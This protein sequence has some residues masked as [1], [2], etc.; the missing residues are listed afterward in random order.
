M[1]PLVIYHLSCLVVAKYLS[2]THLSTTLCRYQASVMGRKHPGTQ[3]QR[4]VVP[5]IPS[6]DLSSCYVSHMTKDHLSHDL[7]PVHVD[8]GP[9]MDKLAHKDSSLVYICYRGYNHIS[10]RIYQQ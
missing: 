2:D 4:C 1:Q 3:P 7:D 6:R 9:S 5:P 8:L 10:G